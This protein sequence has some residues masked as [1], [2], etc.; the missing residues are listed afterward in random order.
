MTKRWNKET[1]EQAV[2]L[3][4]KHSHKYPSQWAAITIVAERLGMSPES[5]RRWIRQYQVDAGAREGITTEE[6]AE[7]RALRRKNAELELRSR[8]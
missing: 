3:V 4:L 5:L 1:R 8:S 2:R 6:A 7:I